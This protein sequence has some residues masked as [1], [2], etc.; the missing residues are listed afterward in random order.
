MPDFDRVLTSL[1][2]WQVYSFLL[3]TSLHVEMESGIPL[4]VFPFILAI[5]EAKG[6]GI[7]TAVTLDTGAVRRLPPFD[8]NQLRNLGVWRRY[9]E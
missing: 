9:T 6:F 3:G 8:R 1:I 4:Q 5:L 7:R 2:V